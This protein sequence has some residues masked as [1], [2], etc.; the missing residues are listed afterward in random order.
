MTDAP[1]M[2]S[3]SRRRDV[4]VDAGVGAGPVR[5][6]LGPDQQLAGLLEGVVVPLPGG[7]QVLGAAALAEGLQD[8]GDGGGALG[9]QVAA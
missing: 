8:G 2:S 5:D 6:H 9:G 3:R 1:S 4:D 7:A